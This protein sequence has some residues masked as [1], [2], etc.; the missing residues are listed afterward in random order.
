MIV[1]E[2]PSRTDGTQP[3]LQKAALSRFLKRAQKAAGLD[4]EVTVLLADDA[5]LKEL[6]RNFRGKNKPTDVLSFPAFENEEGYAGDLAISLDTAQRQADEHGH[7]LEDELRTLM[8][9]GVL[10]LAGYDHETDKGEMRA[11]EAELREKL[12]LPTGLIE[13]TLSA[14]KKRAVTKAKKTAAKKSSAKGT[15]R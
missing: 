14:P 3:S 2:P 7:S 1:T 8:L 6:N 12:K 9:H 15:Q 10:H 13:R 4:G 5:R 11:L